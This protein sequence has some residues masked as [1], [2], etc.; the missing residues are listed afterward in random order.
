MCAPGLRAVTFFLS[1]VCLL[2]VPTLPA[3]AFDEA[4]LHLGRVEGADWHADGIA[5]QIDWHALTRA[6]IV[7]QAD[8]VELPDPLGGLADVRLECADAGLTTE[9]I[10]CPEGTLRASST[11]LGKQHI[12]VSFRYHWQD[13]RIEARLKG[14]RYAGGHFQL[15]VR[16]GSGH[17]SLDLDGD[18]FSLQQVI[19]QAARMGYAV[20]DLEGD[21]RLALLAHLKGSG[22]QL[23]H[24][25]MDMRLQG[26]TF[27][28]ADG[29]IA[30]EDVDLRCLA[31]ISPVTSGWRVALD[32]SGQ[33]G[34]AYLDP[35]FVEVPGQPIHATAK[36][37]WLR[38]RSQL[39][40]HELDYQH[41]GSVVLSAE[42]RFRFAEQ[43]SVEILDVDISAG[44]LP[45]MYDTYLQPWLT[46]TAA[47]SLDTAGHVRARLRVQE[48][49]P[50][51]LSVNL[52]EVDVHDR[53]GLFGLEQ[54]TGKLHW[55]DTQQPESSTL[56][57]QSG[58]LYR[59]ALGAARLEMESVGNAVRLVRPAQLPVLDGAL[60]IDTFKLEY[61]GDQPL[62]WEFDGIL[63]PVSMQ[64]LTAAL[65]WPEFGGKL[66]GVIPA[67]SYAD[68]NLA[69]DGVLLVRVF[70][71]KVT[72]R[73][74]QMTTP[75]GLVPRL[76]VDARVD[77]ID[78]EKL[79][80]TFSFGRIEGRLGGRVDGLLMES[81]RPVAFDA[82]FATP[83]GD[84]SRHRISQKAVDNI[85]NIGGGGV[86]G[87]LSR[88][89]LRFLEDFP[90][91]RLG[92]RCR[93]ENGV[94][95]MGGVAPAGQGYYLVKGRFIPPRLDVVG[96]AERVDW[97]TLVA[98]LISVTGEQQVVV[99]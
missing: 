77:N 15:T 21:G 10:S 85:S 23:T 30:G 96:Y 63:T 6:A 29:S 43:L 33:R 7:L 19:R 9:E 18:S 41:P 82:E 74:L 11:R 38:K 62:R 8:R 65:D 57:W 27:S 87:A 59:V 50:V 75:L 31:D 22:A 2:A 40:L 70:D 80:R 99:E 52:Q 64:L 81:W 83:P 71:G 44:S 39:V 97:E 51:A 53:Q 32:I 47:G 88:S 94:C 25:S 72:L 42:G 79:T 93:L 14:V 17:W 45:A 1:A 36:F 60:Q 86:G 13:G 26:A 16:H 48:G 34:A 5:L 49:A 67:V 4:T 54:V 37:D 3:F 84:R 89:F 58:H 66:S 24:A 95:E 98:Q 69:V 28:N 46:E 92:I 78:L 56:S 35:L 73:D 20:P 76:R 61:A 91:D 90:Y 68:G 55:S 12:P